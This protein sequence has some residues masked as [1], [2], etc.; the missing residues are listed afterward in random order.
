MF[1][2]EARYFSASLAH[3]AWIP[4]PSPRPLLGLLYQELNKEEIPT[5]TKDGVTAVVIA[6]EALGTSSPV[7]TRTPTH[8]M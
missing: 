2:E 5:V 8:Y 4:H 3:A 6:G 7:Y 1:L